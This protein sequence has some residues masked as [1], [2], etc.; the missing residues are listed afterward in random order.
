M[1]TAPQPQ[2]P[3]ALLTA[4]EFA[5][6]PDP[7]Y[8]EELVKGRIVT[9]PPPGVR[10]GLIC[11]RVG[12]ILGNHAEEHDLGFVLNNDAGVITERGPDSV[13][14][15]DVSFYSYAK[16]PKE[17]P[18]PKGYNDLPP[19]LVI[20]VLSPDDRWPKVMVKVG[21]YLL[22]GVSAVIVLDPERRTLHLYEGDQ[23]VRIL[24]ESDELT[25]PAVLGDFRVA[26]GRFFG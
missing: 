8:P 19:D 22:A 12:R 11:N 7:G 23:P 26:V 15:P 9:K 5:K 4:E 10:H 21:E 20:E 16:L 17:G 3:P 2:S 14:G 1:A 25:L 6:R 18:A 13:R 24:G